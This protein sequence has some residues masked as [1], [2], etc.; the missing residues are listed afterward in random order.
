MNRARFEFLVN[1]LNITNQ[2]AS[3]FR[4]MLRLPYAEYKIIIELMLEGKVTPEDFMTSTGMIADANVE[5]AKKIINDKAKYNNYTAADVTTAL[6][7]KNKEIP[8][9]SQASNLVGYKYDYMSDVVNSD[10]ILKTLPYNVTGTH[11]ITD[12][13]FDTIFPNLIQI[14]EAGSIDAA[15]KDIQLKILKRRITK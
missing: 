9:T 4:Q 7:N 11:I 3:I 14:T 13:S 8:N 15:K 5:N 10:N 6:T 2:N 12:G 1:K